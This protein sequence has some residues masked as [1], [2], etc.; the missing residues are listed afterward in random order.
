MVTTLYFFIKY[1]YCMNK[2]HM[3]VF[4]NLI[5]LISYEFRNQVSLFDYLVLFLKFQ[6]FV[7]VHAVPP[8]AR[9]GHWIPWDWS[10]RLFLRRSLGGWG[11]TLVLWKSSQ[12]YY[13][14]SHVSSLIFFCMCVQMY[15]YCRCVCTCVNTCESQKTTS[16]VILSHYHLAFCLF[17]FLWR[18][19]FNDV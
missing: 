1:V 4:L 17:L 19:A 5:V 18:L 13:P 2:V 9:R 6:F 15:K 14:L 8:G 12:W 3:W 7:C 11:R 16:T 10:Y